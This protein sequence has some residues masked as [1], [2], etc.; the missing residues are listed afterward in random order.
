MY[1]RV[2][3]KSITRVHFSLLIFFSL[4][5]SSGNVCVQAKI[6][7]KRYYDVGTNIGCGL[8]GEIYSCFIY[9]HNN[10]T[11][12]LPHQCYGLPLV[13]S[14]VFVS[15]A[16]DMHVSKSIICTYVKFFQKIN[17]KLWFIQESVFGPWGSWYDELKIQV[18]TMNLLSLYGVNLKWRKT[19][20]GFV[21]SIGSS[22][23]LGPNIFINVTN[24]AFKIFGLTNIPP[25]HNYKSIADSKNCCSVFCDLA[26]KIAL[27]RFEFR[28]NRTLELGFIFTNFVSYDDNTGV[29]RLKNPFDNG[30]YHLFQLY[31]DFG[32]LKQTL[33]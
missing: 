6:D 32:S 10:I 24:L 23:S 26:V 5:E 15:K 12:P 9:S 31:V 13:K 2:A 7:D 3:K 29:V 30:I 20:K 22:I 8:C 18:G 16:S 21:K 25:F 11:N 4:C 33:Q 28:S 27:C 17:D 14:Y 19:N 1:W